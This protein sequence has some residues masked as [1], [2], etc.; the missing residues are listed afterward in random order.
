V[1]SVEEADNTIFLKME[2]VEG[3]TLTELIPAK[4]FPVDQLLKLAIPLADAVSAAHTRGIT[5]RDL[6]PANVMVASDGRLKVLDFGLA[7]LRE[8]AKVLDGSVTALSPQPLT[9]EGRIVGTITYMSPEQ[10]EGKPIDHRSDI[11]SLG[12]MLY[13]MATGERPFKGDTEVSTLSAILRD[14]PRPVTDIQPALP[15]DLAKIIRRLLTKDPE[16]RFQSAKDLRNELEELKQDLDSG[17]S[18]PA[19]APAA[20]QR[21]SGRPVWLWPTAGLVFV[22]AVAL[23]WYVISSSGSDA[24]A[25]AALQVNFTHLT[26]G[27]DVETNPSLSPDGKWIVYASGGDIHL[28]NVTS[29]VPFANLTKDEPAIDSQP[30]FS[31]DGEQIAFRSARGGGGIFVMTRTGESVRRLTDRG[32]D[33]A[34]T[35]DG[36]FVVFA[37]ATTVDP[38]SRVSVSEGWK[39]EVATNQITA[40]DFMQPAVSPKAERVAYWSLPVTPTPPLEFSGNNRDLW[41]MRLDGTDPVR[42]TDDAATDWSPVWSHDG[43]FLYFASDRGGSMNLWRIAIDESSGRVRGQP[44]AVT[45]PSTWLGMISRSGDGRVFAY[46]AYDFTRNIARIGFD[47]VKGAV[48]GDRT[49]VTTGTVDWTRPDPS[50]DGSLVL[51]LSYHRQEDVYISRAD[52]SGRRPLTNDVDKDRLPRWS[53]DGTQIAFYSNRGGAFSLWTINPDG[54]GRRQRVNMNASVIYPLWSPDGRSLMATQL[55]SR[56]NYLFTLGDQVLTAPTETLPPHPSGRSFSAWAWSSD[57]LKIVGTTGGISGELSVYSLDTKTYTDIVAGSTPVW[58]GDN[59]RLIYASG[60]RIYIVDTVTKVSREVL[61]DA[62]T[63][64]D[65]RLTRDNRTLF[66]THGTIGADIW[67]MT[68]K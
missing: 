35:P 13:E 8:D 30:A 34:W 4:G 31:P 64:A 61:A 37:T 51:F 33:P 12:V 53:P 27:V 65:P 40:G 9:G 62:E 42:V 63:L 20:A 52:G 23:A 25:S 11:F 26:S 28:Q 56:R 39:V 47:P 32:F 58:L 38:D 55:A 5:H 14:T 50:P 22:A 59:R 67:L 15:R 16:H 57:G 1:H 46:A 49:A 43:A 17:D 18:L 48:T 54:G 3:R 2:L 66:F 24:P 36:R 29:Q 19:A 21:P 60:P 45:T 10:A 41:T 44:E 68:V 7:K 6:K